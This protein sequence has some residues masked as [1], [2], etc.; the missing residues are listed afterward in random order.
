[1][2]KLGLEGNFHPNST[3]K[4]LVFNNQQKFNLELM[5]TSLCEI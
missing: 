5:V 1:M 3:K 2:Q 4:A